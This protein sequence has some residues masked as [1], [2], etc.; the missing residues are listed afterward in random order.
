[1]RNFLLFHLKLLQWEI[2]DISNGSGK[3]ST[4]ATLLGEFS[5]EQCLVEKSHVMEYDGEI[6][7]SFPTA[8]T[9]SGKLHIPNHFFLSLSAVGNSLSP[10]RFAYFPLN[11]QLENH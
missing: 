8:C 3:F 4:A 1:V 10:L 2:S 5:T 9:I 6:V 11:L 7:G